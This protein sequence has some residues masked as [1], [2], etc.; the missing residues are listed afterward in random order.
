MLWR[1]GGEKKT[2]N[3][4]HQ[5]RFERNKVW[6][7]RKYT[8][9]NTQTHT[10]SVREE[11]SL[12]SCETE[13]GGLLWRSMKEYK[14]LYKE[15]EVIGRGNFGILASFFVGKQFHYFVVPRTC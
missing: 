1:G 14:K 3:R 9:K 13:E 12:E 5:N 8:R 6:L 11:R 10:K 15:K 2:I 7:I 4:E